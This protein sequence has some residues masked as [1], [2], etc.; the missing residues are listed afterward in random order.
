MKGNET[1]CYILLP[2][3]YYFRWLFFT[4]LVWIFPSVLCPV[5]FNWKRRN[6][7]S[8]S[9]PRILSAV[10][11]G[12]PICG[13]VTLQIVVCHVTIPCAK[14]LGSWC[15][16]CRGTWSRATDAAPMGVGIHTHV[17]TQYMF[18]LSFWCI[19]LI[20]LAPKFWHTLWLYMVHSASNSK[21]HWRSVLLHNSA[22][23]NA[24]FVYALF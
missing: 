23:H 18:V 20:A 3:Y 13:I 4:L 10:E 16:S 21:T 6:N 17:S 7:C 9:V 19:S 8:S 22:L 11:R 24:G 12:T 5:W 14:I 1:V 2:L 15:F